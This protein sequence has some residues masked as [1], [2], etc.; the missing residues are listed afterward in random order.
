MTT[1]I[2]SFPAVQRPFAESIDVGLGDGDGNLT[3]PELAKLGAILRSELTT[4]T[5]EVRKRAGNSGVKVNAFPDGPLIAMAAGS[6][7]VG[8]K[9]AI[10][11]RAEVDQFVP[12]ALH[13]IDVIMAMFQRLIARPPSVPGTSV[14][15]IEQLFNQ[16]AVPVPA[17][18]V[19]QAF[20]AALQDGTVSPK[21]ARAIAEEWAATVADGDFQVLP[22]AK[23]P[24]AQ[25]SARHAVPYIEPGLQPQ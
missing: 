7:L 23:A 11:T 9:N 8:N 16:T 17:S 19:T 22:E 20:D 15:K 3:K 21:E 1:K 24:M 5:A 12:K 4:T 6:D 10:V 18:T 14:G 25:R 13:Q 2:S